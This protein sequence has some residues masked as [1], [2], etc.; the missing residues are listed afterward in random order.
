ML[1]AGVL[2]LVSAAS[3]GAAAAAVATG[4]VTPVTELPS[5][6]RFRSG[7][8]FGL[9]VG[10]GL[11]GATGYPNDTLKIGDPAYYSA[12]GMT[13]GPA[14]SLF[15]MGALSDYVSVGFFFDHATSRNGDWRTAANSG[16]LRLEGFPLVA[17][18]PALQG[19]GVVARF[20]IGGGSLTPTAVPGSPAASDGT[21]SF[22]GAGVLYEWSFLH[23]L[24]GHFGVGPSVEYDAVWSPAFE[25]H[26]LVAS[27]RV[28]FYGGP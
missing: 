2:V 13:L 19:L 27:A 21:Q 12:S 23:L 6:H 18:V 11:V 9:S 25:R 17:L 26:G 4:D 5:A 16:G 8:V 20:G 15:V 14:E 7:L 28:V 10:A 22:A 24:G 1:A 3:S